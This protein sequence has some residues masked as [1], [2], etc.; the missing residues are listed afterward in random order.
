MHSFNQHLSTKK[1]FLQLA[2]FLLLQKDFLK[3]FFLLHLCIEVHQQNHH[4]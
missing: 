4:L 3:Y 2:L 1:D